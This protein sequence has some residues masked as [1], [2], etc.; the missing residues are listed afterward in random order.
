MKSTVKVRTRM[1]SDSDLAENWAGDAGGPLRIDC[2]VEEHGAIQDRE[3]LHGSIVGI[4][5][6]QRSVSECP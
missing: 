1:N 3:G 4:E 5:M 6:T 2:S